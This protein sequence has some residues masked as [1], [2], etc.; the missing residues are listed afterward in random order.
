[1]FVQEAPIALD[2]RPQQFRALGNFAFH[3][4]D[5]GIAD[6]GVECGDV[7]MACGGGGH[8]DS[9]A[10]ALVQAERIR[11][12]AMFEIDE[13]ESIRNHEAHGARQ[14]LGDVLQP[15]PDQIAQL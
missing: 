2:A 13:M 8:C 11:G 3:F 14:L 15:L 6:I 5:Q 1:M 9:T 10:G 4:R 12:T 7:R